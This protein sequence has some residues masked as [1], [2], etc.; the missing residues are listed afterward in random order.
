MEPAEAFNVGYLT[1]MVGVPLRG[2]ELMNLV[3]KHATGGFATAVDAQ[4]NGFRAHNAQ[5]VENVLRVESLLAK[6]GLAKPARP[7]TADQWV[8]WADQASK[9]AGASLPSESAAAAALIAGG[10]F[11][12]LLAAVQL[13]QILVGLLADAPDDKELVAQIAGHVGH[14][15][16]A[17]EQIELVLR[18]PALSAKAK[19]PL[20]AAV[21]AYRGVVIDAAMPAAARHEALTKLRAE[22]NRQGPV[23]ASAF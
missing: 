9:S 5:T 13:A 2:V 16:H 17:I 6:H 19:P 3:G 20:A 8:T 10:Y 21:A 7:Q 18:H 12:D 14:A 15:A 11:G 1:S 4:I 22:I 23:L